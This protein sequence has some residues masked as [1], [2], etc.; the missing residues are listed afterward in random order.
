MMKFGSFGTFGTSKDDKWGDFSIWGRSAL[1]NVPVLLQLLMQSTGG[2][3]FTSFSFPLVKVG[4][5]I[6]RILFHFSSSATLRADSRIPFRPKFCTG[7][8]L[9]QKAHGYTGRWVKVS[10]PLPHDRNTK[11]APPQSVD[12]VPKVI[13][14]LPQ[15]ANNRNGNKSVR[16]INDISPRVHAG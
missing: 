5:S 11:K 3:C 7:R 16:G 10:S 15:T 6:V 2:L 9:Q 4:D 13:S 1:R 8:M 12:L 14:A